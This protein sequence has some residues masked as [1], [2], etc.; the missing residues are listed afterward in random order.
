MD[1]QREGKSKDLAC[2]KICLWECMV[3]AWGEEGKED[4][5][6]AGEDERVPS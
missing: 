4:L 2:N 5:E 6:E 1:S 3:K